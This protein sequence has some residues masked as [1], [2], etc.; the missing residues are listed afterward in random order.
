MRHRTA[1]ISA[2]DLVSQE[3]R[4]FKRIAEPLPERRIRRARAGYYG[5]ITELDEHIGQIWDALEFAGQLANTRRRGEALDDHVPDA[6][7]AAAT[8]FP[9]YVCAYLNSS[10][11]RQHLLR[12]GKTTAGCKTITTFK[13][14]VLHNSSPPRS[15]FNVVLRTSS[16][17]RVSQ[18]QSRTPAAELLCSLA[19][20]SWHGC[21]T[22]VQSVGMHERI[23]RAQPPEASIELGG[24]TG[25]RW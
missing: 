17:R 3:L 9:E 7:L 16:K 20:P 10:F 5:L 21:S 11:G 15:P 6:F 1:I 25:G 14:E 2:D 12:S 22:L 23:G 4:H 19:P 8:V 13:R 18:F 24:Q